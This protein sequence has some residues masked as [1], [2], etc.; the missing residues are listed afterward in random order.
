MQEKSELSGTV[1]DNVN[2]YSHRGEQPPKL[3]TG[4]PYDSVVPFL[5]T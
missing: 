5:V 3:K 2:W 1:G 4:L